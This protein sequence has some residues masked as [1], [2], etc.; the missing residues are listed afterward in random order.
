[1][2]CL[3]LSTKDLL[4]YLNMCLACK[5]RR[6]QFVYYLLIAGLDIFFISRTTETFVREVASGSVF[7]LGMD[8]VADPVSCLFYNNNK[9]TGTS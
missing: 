3:I 6:I 5:H 9:L 1:M 7:L 2:V 4:I 8:V